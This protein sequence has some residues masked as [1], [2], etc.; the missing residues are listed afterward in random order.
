MSI[1]VLSASELT[2]RYGVHTILTKAPPSIHE[3]DRIGLVGRNG[4]GKSTFLR[5]AAGELQPDSGAVT[6]KRELLTGYLPQAFEL[7]EEASVPTNILRGAQHVL[8]MIAEYETAPA[9][10]NRS[11]ELIECIE[12]FDGWSL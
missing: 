6:R 12:H 7:A 3:N 4:T 8:D 2:I 11:G 5:V 1:A 10:S 9:E